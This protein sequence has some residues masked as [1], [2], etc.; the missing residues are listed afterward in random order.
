MIPIELI[1]HVSLNVRDLEK[2]KEFYKAIL[3]LQTS[4][5]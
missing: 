4:S 5:F 1:H 3:G 2:S